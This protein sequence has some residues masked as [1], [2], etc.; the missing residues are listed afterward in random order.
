MGSPLGGK[1][2]QPKKSTQDSGIGVQA[3]FDMD[4]NESANSINN[5]ANLN[6]RKD[7]MYRGGLEEKL[8]SFYVAYQQ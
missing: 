3:D 1:K 4:L 5:Y 7:T 2:K 8:A 6:S